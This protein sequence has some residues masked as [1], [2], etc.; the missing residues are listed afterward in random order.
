MN[1]RSSFDIDC[2]SIIPACG[3]KCP[4]CIQEIESTLTG[5]PSVS[6][7]YIEAEGEEQRLIIEHDPGTVAVEQLIDVLKTL[8]SFYEAFFI[9]TVIGNPEKE[10]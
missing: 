3:F 10:S 6:K 4:K 8:P 1:S 7:A 9:P 5:V 2:S